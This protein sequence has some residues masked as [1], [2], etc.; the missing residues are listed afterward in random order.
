MKRI[1][2]LLLLLSVL[3]LATACGG[4]SAQPAAEANVEQSE[5][6]AAQQLAEDVEQA[7]EMVTE[8]APAEPATAPCEDFFR[9]CVT[10]TVSGS[11]SA[12]ATGGMGGNIESCAAWVA[13]GEPRI[14][15]LPMMQTAA[16]SAITVALT[17]IGAYTGPGTYDLQPVAKEGMPDMFPA[18]AV[19][20]RT[21]NNGEGSTAVVTIAPDGSGTLEAKG[22]FEI[23]SVQIANPDPEARI[24][25]SMQWTC[26][27][28]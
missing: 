25:L 23:A 9:Y 5:S 1:V 14:L 3:L 7:V 4:E 27:D 16:G 24:D 18:I 28:N 6:E 10:S 15:E 12:E 17:R 2:G 26:R 21:F 19:D 11:V 20:G 8:A 13:E 22:L